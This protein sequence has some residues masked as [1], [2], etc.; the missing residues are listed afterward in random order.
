MR[1]FLVHPE[2]WAFAASNAWSD[3]LL[4]RKLRSLEGGVLITTRPAF[5]VIAAKLAPARV[6]TVAQEHLNYNAHRPR[7]AP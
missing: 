3:V 2:D 7:L 6:V 1:S 5:N 4:I